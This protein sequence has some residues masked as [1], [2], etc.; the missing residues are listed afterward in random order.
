MWRVSATTGDEAIAG[1]KWHK[2]RIAYFKSLSSKKRNWWQNVF[3]NALNQCECRWLS[4]SVWKPST[5]TLPQPLPSAESTNWS[6]CSG[7]ACCCCV[8]GVPDNQRHW[9]S[10]SKIWVGVPKGSGLD[11]TRENQTDPFLQDHTKQWNSVTP[12]KE[13][14][15]ANAVRWNDPV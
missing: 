11:W 9:Q 7:S 2:L 4:T 3:P 6:W 10:P 14:L 15:W 1:Q 12:T 8:V 5:P 13:F